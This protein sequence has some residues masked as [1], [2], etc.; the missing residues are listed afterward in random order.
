MLATGWL[1]YELSGHAN[2][3]K[4]STREEGLLVT[5]LAEVSPLFVDI[6]LRQGHMSNLNHKKDYLSNSK[7]LQLKNSL[8]KNT[9]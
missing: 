2:L 3:Q 4:I 5:E 8:T 7:L 9:A 6:P 1:G